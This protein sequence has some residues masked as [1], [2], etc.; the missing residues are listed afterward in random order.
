MTNIQGIKFLGKNCNI[1][2]NLTQQ[3]LQTAI[4]YIVT[5][6][7]S[8]FTSAVDSLNIKRTAENRISNTLSSDECRKTPVTLKN[9]KIINYPKW[10]ISRRGHDLEGVFRNLFSNKVAFGLE[11]LLDI[12]ERLPDFVDIELIRT[13]K[14]TL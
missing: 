10:I 4:D 9:K 7:E 14:A 12:Q 5:E 11:P 13:L 8:K 1:L 6:V 2:E 3:E